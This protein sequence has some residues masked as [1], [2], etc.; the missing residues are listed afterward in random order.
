MRLDFNVLWVEDNQGNVQSQKTAIERNVRREG[1][2]LRVQF[3]ASVEAAT[4]FLS[5]NIYGDHIDLVLM[6][7]DL[8]PGKKGDEGLSAV[9]GIF[10]YK[11]IVFYSGMSTA[12]LLAK[13][14]AQNVQGIFVSNRDALPDV[15]EG[16]FENLVKKVLDIDHSRGI[17]MGATSDIDTVVFSGLS[18]LFENCDQKQKDDVLA[19]VQSRLAEKKKNFGEAINVIKSVS[20]VKELSDHHAIYTSD[21]RLRLLL[22]LFKQL[23]LH[24]DK[25]KQF[26]FYRKSVMPR[27]NDL[28][29]IRVEPKG[30]SRKFFDRKGVELSADDMRKLRVELLEFQDVLSDIFGA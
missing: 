4:V 7:F 27:R 8:G 26:E 9:R 28:A 16:V 22:K 13:V 24:Q 11:D 19:E 2:R 5:D 21:D 17:V 29:H 30:F 3:A 1:F 20:H 25:A 23:T 18:H 6:D 12:E 15:V 10:P 14:S